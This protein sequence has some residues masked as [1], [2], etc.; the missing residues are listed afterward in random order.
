M[1]RPM[2]PRP[3]KPMTCAMRP[4]TRRASAS[5]PRRALTSNTR[6]SGRSRSNQPSHPV[7]PRLDGLLATRD[8][9]IRWLTGSEDPRG[10]RNGPT[11]Q[12]DHLIIVLAQPQDLVAATD[13]DDAA[14]LDGESL[15]NGQRV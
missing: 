8:P 12:V 7:D 3:I 1:G 2:M 6:R 10:R 13:L 11:F 15:G 5:D 9:E 4:P 14:V